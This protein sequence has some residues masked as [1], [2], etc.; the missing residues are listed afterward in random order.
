MQLIGC[1]IRG[2]PPVLGC[3]SNTLQMLSTAPLD[4]RIVSDMPTSRCTDVRRQREK[5]NVFTV[6]CSKWQN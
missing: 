2:A 4:Q 3:A 6:R 5:V 1:H